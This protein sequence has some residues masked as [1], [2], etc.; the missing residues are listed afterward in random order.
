MF[1]GSSKVGINWPCSRG[2][3]LIEG[4][5]NSKHEWDPSRQTVWLSLL[6]SLWAWAGELLPTE[7]TSNRWKGSKKQTKQTS[8]IKRL[9]A[10]ITVLNTLTE[11]NWE[12]KQVFQRPHGMRAGMRS[13]YLSSW[14]FLGNSRAMPSHLTITNSCP[15]SMYS[16]QWRTG[17]WYTFKSGQPGS[18]AE[19]TPG[20]LDPGSF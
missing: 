3:P 18:R 5:P 9:L 1:T 13:L 20:S 16:R 17:V 10:L 12:P 7:V 11:T 6:K 8:T 14:Q 4:I 2:C 19:L 15:H